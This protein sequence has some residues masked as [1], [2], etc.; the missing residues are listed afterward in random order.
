MQIDYSKVQ[1]PETK[2][3]KDK[4]YKNPKDFSF[5]ER[6]AEILKLIEVAGHPKIVSQVELAERYNVSQQ[7]ISL[8]IQALK[9]AI[10]NMLGGEMNITNYALYNKT[11]K[12]L[13]RENKLVEACKILKDWNDWLYSSGIENKT[14]EKWE[15]EL[16]TRIPTPDEVLDEIKK[17]RENGK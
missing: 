9:K 15:G 13:I 17:R 2:D 12:T 10:R 6:R 3:T 4:R 8:D 14:P 11:L 7:Q 5:V 1:L 16:T